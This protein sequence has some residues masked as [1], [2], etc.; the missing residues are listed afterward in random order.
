MW[1]SV[2]L[3]EYQT[4]KYQIDQSWWADALTYAGLIT[5]AMPEIKGAI[6]TVGFAGSSLTVPTAD[7]QTVAV[8]GT[9]YYKISNYKEQPNG[10]YE[11]RDSP[12]HDGPCTDSDTN[13]GPSV[14]SS[15]QM[16]WMLSNMGYNMK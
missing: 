13:I 1:Y 11:G 2:A 5:V 14:P 7:V 4:F 3:S 9:E 6:V 8:P 12:V 15:D 16:K 10:L